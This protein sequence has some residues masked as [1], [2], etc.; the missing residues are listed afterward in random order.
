MNWTEH[1][2]VGPAPFLILFLPIGVHCTCTFSDCFVAIF[3]VRF[4]APNFRSTIATGCIC[5]GANEIDGWESKSGWYFVSAHATRCG[6]LNAYFFFFVLLSRS[7]QNIHIQFWWLPRLFFNFSIESEWKLNYLNCD[8]REHNAQFSC[9]CT[10]RGIVFGQDSCEYKSQ[11]AIIRAFDRENTI[12]K[13]MSLF[14]TTNE[15]STI[16]IS[17]H[18]FCVYRCGFD[19]KAYMLLTMCV[20]GSQCVSMC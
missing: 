1:T 19:T 7:E 3:V 2:S 18:I 8:V 10:V 13:S 14:M 5:A 12:T 17:F 9:G 16:F 4:C 11:T 15:N 20:I 6:D